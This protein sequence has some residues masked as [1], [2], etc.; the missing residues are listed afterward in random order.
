[1]DT[2]TT[3]AVRQV[4]MNELGLT[5][6]S[7]RAEMEKIVEETVA[8]HIASTTFE[9]KLRGHVYDQFERLRGEKTGP[10]GGWESIRNIVQDQASRDVKA[11]LAAHLRFEAV[12]DVKGE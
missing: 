7:V 3:N 1:M 2:V 8:R 12:T 4:L 6:E 10:W 5:R 11:W 9:A